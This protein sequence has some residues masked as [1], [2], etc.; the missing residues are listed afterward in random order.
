[1][2]DSGLV[3]NGKEIGQFSNLLTMLKSKAIASGASYENDIEFVE[4]EL[5][6]F[7]GAAA[8][9]DR[10]YSNDFTPSL[11]SSKFNTVVTDI[12]NYLK[13]G[14]TNNSGRNGHNFDPARTAYMES[15]LD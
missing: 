13:N 2:V 10:Y 4:T 15:L 1:M 9:L 8:K 5:P 6:V 11:F 7:L 14:N 12:Q 3:W